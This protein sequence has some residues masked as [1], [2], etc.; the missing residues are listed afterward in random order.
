[1]ANGLGG[2]KVCAQCS[3]QNALKHTCARR[4]ARTHLNV[5]SLSDD[6]DGRHQYSVY[7]EDSV[8]FWHR[9]LAGPYWVHVG[10]GRVASRWERKYRQL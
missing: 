1:M 10:G 7:V 4:H 2:D 8:R 9:M 6:D 3:E 5:K